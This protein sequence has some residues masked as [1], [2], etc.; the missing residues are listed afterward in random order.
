[1]SSTWAIIFTVFLSCCSVSFVISPMT[2]VSISH[3]NLCVKKWRHVLDISRAL[4]SVMCGCF[5]K[6]NKTTYSPVRS[7]VV[8]HPSTL[9]DTKPPA[10]FLTFQYEVRLF[11]TQSESGHSVCIH[12][13]VLR[14]GVVSV[15]HWRNIRTSAM[16]S[17]LH[18]DR[19]Q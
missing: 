4:D 1:M 10:D 11:P 14:L 7:N 16:R 9:Y 8:P 6:E 19:K 2:S 17:R 3:P 5:S 12:D 13:V 18:A 15:E